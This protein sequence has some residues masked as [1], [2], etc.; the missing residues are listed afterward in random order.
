MPRRVK[1]GTEDPG[2]TE[3]VPRQLARGGAALVDL[4]TAPVQLL[5]FLTGVLRIH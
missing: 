3:S 1:V 2:R 4:V 5:L